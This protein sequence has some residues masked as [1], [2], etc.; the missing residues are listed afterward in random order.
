MQDNFGKAIEANREY[1]ADNEKVQEDIDIYN[2]SYMHFT[3]SAGHC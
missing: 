2:K 1:I 3:I